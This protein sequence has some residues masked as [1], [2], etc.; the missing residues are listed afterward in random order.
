MKFQS[1]LLSTLF[2]ICGS[3]MANE[4]CG[5]EKGLFT[6]QFSW[7]SESFSKKNSVEIQYK[8]D[9]LLKKSKSSGAGIISSPK[10]S[11]LSLELSPG[12]YH[13]EALKMV[14][15][16]FEYGK[17][18][19]IPF[20]KSFEVKAG[21]VT[22]GGLFF[23]GKETKESLNIYHLTL[24]N[25][26]DIERYVS[27]HYPTFDAAPGAIAHA[28]E[29]TDD[30]KLESIIKAYAATL[31]PAEENRKRP[32]VTYLFTTLGIIIKM[33]KDASGKVLEHELIKTPSYQEIV[34]V[35]FKDQKMICRLGNGDY[36]YGE[37]EAPE[38]LPLPK[39]MKAFGT[40][41][42]LGPS[43][44]M[45]LEND[46]GLHFATS[47]FNWTSQNDFRVE[48]KFGLLKDQDYSWPKLYFG[49]ENIYVFSS[50]QGKYRRLLRS[51]YDDLRFEEIALGK[52]VRQVPMVTETK[53]QLILG[54]DLKLF[55]SAK[56]PAYLYVQDK[57]SASWQVIDLPRGDCNRFGVDPDNDLRYTLT[58]GGEV[59]YVSEDSG[60]TWTLQKSTK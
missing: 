54:P 33:K 38:Y 28:W 22:N 51:A 14:G 2:L 13:F 49:K 35:V 44:W 4:D 30:K 55:A 26:N 16:D 41:Y 25:D 27:V 34:Q 29:F 3:L 32:K 36:W 15:P 12:I 53:S 6:I 50:S 40:L 52:E 7:N 8:K 45:F 10:N 19:K 23:I 39:Q 20:D 31:I 21:Q 46:Y 37:P 43:K 58:C 9:G 24:D 47:N 17:Y 57:G 60:G 56:R 42:Y 18:L 11:V 48:R 59:T 5:Q 1:I